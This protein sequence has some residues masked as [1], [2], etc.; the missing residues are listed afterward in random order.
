MSLFVNGTFCHEPFS[1]ID[2]LALIPL[3]S[4]PSPARC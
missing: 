1:E 4:L 2:Y 3:L